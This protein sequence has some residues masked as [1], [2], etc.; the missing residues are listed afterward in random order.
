[1][2]LC[3]Y[4]DM[5]GAPFTGAHQYR[6][7][8]VAAVDLVLTLLLA[9]FISVRYKVSVITTVVGLMLLS[10]VAHMFFCV[11]TAL[12]KMLGIST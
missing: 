9:L 5:F 11:D 2:S 10:V 1:M 4:K 7:M 12:L 6:F 8:G 3:Q